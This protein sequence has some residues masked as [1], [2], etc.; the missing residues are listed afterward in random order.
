MSKEPQKKSKEHNYDSS[1]TFTRYERN[2]WKTVAAQNDMKDFSSIKKEIKRM[3]NTLDVVEGETYNNEYGG[4][5][6]CQ[7]VMTEQ[8]LPKPGQADEHSDK[9]RKKEQKMIAMKNQTCCICHQARCA[10]T[11]ECSLCRENFHLDCINFSEN[12]ARSGETN[13]F[14]TNCIYINYIPFLKYVLSSSNIYD[15]DLQNSMMVQLYDKF[16]CLDRVST[17]PSPTNVD[18]FSEETAD[19]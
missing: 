1:G 8:T 3:C 4:K 6:E 9:I 5:L 12:L 16:C 18:V 14:C 13:Y 19:L 15:N 17:T 11:I 7:P 2:I 10:N